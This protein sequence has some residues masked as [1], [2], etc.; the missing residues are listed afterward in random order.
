MK[1]IKASEIKSGET[2]AFKEDG[3][4]FIAVHRDATLFLV[5]VYDDSN[6]DRSKTIRLALRRPG[7]FVLHE[8]RGVDWH[9][10]EAGQLRATL[11]PDDPV[12]LVS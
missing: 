3:P 6:V 2:I 4:H 7:E 1:K 10:R 11:K 8:D 12:W 9:Q 5:G